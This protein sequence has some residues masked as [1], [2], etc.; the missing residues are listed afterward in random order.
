MRIRGAAVRLTIYLDGPDVWHHKPLYTEIVHRAHQ[1]GLAGAT[2]IRGID[3]F[4]GTP[5]AN[6]RFSF[7]VQAPIMIIIIDERERIQTFLDT[8][9]GVLSNGAIALDEVEVIWYLPEPRA[10]KHGE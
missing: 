5:R 10:A 8:L 3:G 9:D 2:V 1:H 7:A 6:R 4:A